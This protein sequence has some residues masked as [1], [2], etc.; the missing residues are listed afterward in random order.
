MT[1]MTHGSPS[2][3]CKGCGQSGTPAKVDCN[4]MCAA[5]FALTLPVPTVANIDRDS[6]LAWTS[7]LLA[8]RAIAPDTSPPRA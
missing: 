5:V 2:D 1:G 7:E 6:A 8:S 3:S 4:A